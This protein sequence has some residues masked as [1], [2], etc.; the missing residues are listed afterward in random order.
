MEQANLVTVICIAFNHEKWIVKALDSILLQ[1][2]E[3]KE[4]I[5]VDN[6]SSDLS[7]G[8]IRDWVKKHSLELPVSAIY[9]SE[10]IP[11]C[12]LFN[13]MLNLANGEYTVDLSGDDFL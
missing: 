2:Y 5:I 10:P 3:A 11:Y 9:K 6:G 8:I 12:E 13:E 1:S 4:L 7:A